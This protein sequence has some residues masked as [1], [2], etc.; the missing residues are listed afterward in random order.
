MPHAPICHI[1][2]KTAKFT[3]WYPALFAF[4]SHILQS[5]KKYEDEV[6]RGH[7]SAGIRRV[8]ND[9]NGIDILK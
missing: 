9:G 1:Y 7:L 6:N 3:R 2:D 4:S 5:V 8:A